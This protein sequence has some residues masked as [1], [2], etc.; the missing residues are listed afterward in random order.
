M[1]KLTKTRGESGL[2]DRG[3]A[4]GCEGD[5]L[6]TASRIDAHNGAQAMSAREIAPVHL[7]LTVTPSRV[8]LTGDHIMVSAP[9]MG[10]RPGLSEAVDEMRRRRPDGSGAGAA[11]RASRLL[12][13]SFLPALVYDELAAK[14][15][16]AGRSRASVRLGVAAEGA[17]ANLP[18]ECLLLSGVAAALH[19]QVSMYRLIAGRP[20]I[21]K[22]GPLRILV[23]IA[24]PDRGGGPVLDYERELRNISLAV[25]AARRGVAHVRVVPFAT[26]QAIYAALQDEPVHVLH[27]SGHGTR[28]VLQLENED[29]SACQLTADMFADRA[30]PP[31]DV[32]CVISLA[33]CYTD[34]AAPGETSFAARLGQRTAAAVIATQTSVTDVYATKVFA[35]LYKRLSQRTAP[36]V[37][38][39][40]ADSRR[41]VQQQLTALRHRRDQRLAR[42]DEWSVVTLLAAGGAV[43]LWGPDSATSPP[44]LRPLT[45]R[46]VIAGLAPRDPWY[47]VG[48]RREQRQWPRLLAAPG[49]AGMVIYG[50]GGVG[51]TSLAAEL[52]IQLS[53]RG[54]PRVL[55]SVTGPL[56]VGTLLSA[57]V[58]ALRRELLTQDAR[59]TVMAAADQIARSDLAWPDRFA[60]L[61][62][63]VLKAVPLLLVLDNFEDNLTAGST[64]RTVHDEALAGL[65]AAWTAEPG[66]SRIIV[67][68]RYPFALPGGA[69]RA[70][71]FQQL[72]PLSFAETRKLA[73]SLP[74][75]DQ[76]SEAQLMKVWRLVGGHP[77]SLEYLDTLLAAGDAR[78][79]DISS[80]LTELTRR[81]T[82]D[83]AKTALLPGGSRLDTKLSE[84][85]ALA[86]ADFLLGQLLAELADTPRRTRSAARRLCVP[87]ARRPR[88]FAIPLRNTRR[89]ARQQPRLGRG[90]ARGD[91][92]SP[93]HWSSPSAGSRPFR[94]PG[95]NSG[96]ASSA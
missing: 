89:N 10:Q 86:S 90:R 21:R 63:H 61:A 71:L 17:L 43:P 4:I 26:P 42:L 45:T 68:S 24:S 6:G 29:G 53:G 70:L 85:I 91:Q 31:D 28:G 87:H 1:R 51:K 58:A 41:E 19:P 60:A 69:E 79:P 7:V 83:S 9:H 64:S 92:D 55:V 16:Q 39:A 34:A 50:I 67:T 95:G 96:S 11:R 25:R 57:V 14:L 49:P 2:C 32:P 44:E 47:F 94:R 22:P 13:E 36:D 52:A 76:L 78:Y 56:T 8:Q 88:S 59:G 20:T 54:D 73:W 72:G 80:R 38:T 62:R 23:A 65:L 93:C 48:R 82:D 15:E 74:Q 27:I 77:R 46:P 5:R 18:W 81:A 84:V 35:S 12:T 75:L 37:V 66:Q 33:A 3:F 40:L 30:L